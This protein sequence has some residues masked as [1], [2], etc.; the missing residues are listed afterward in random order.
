MHPARL[1]DVGA[2]PAEFLPRLKALEP[3]FRRHEYI[4]SVTQHPVARAV[5]YD[6]EDFLRTQPVRGYHCTREP[7]P[8][9]F[10]AHGLRL[11]DVAS[12][13]AEFLAAF[14][15]LFTEG[16]K[17]D[18]R[19]AWARYFVGTGQLPARNGMLW[20]CL[21]EATAHSYGTQVFFDHFGGEA[22][23]MPLK[24]HPT[25]APKLG[26]IGTPVIVEARLQPGTTVPLRLALP[27]LSA[28]HRTIRPDAHVWDA[29]TNIRQP[30][31]P[32]DVLAVTPV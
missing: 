10:K 26:K 9:Y 13:Q 22:V 30:V 2:I 24:D 12:H 16:E 27:L 23:F 19:R 6:L 15:H 11:T 32:A 25:I 3:E 28:Y 1:D 18:L 31:P 29:E 5:Q 21:T 8:G 4:D 14:G 17:E 7:A 20:F